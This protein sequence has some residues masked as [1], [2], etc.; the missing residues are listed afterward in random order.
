MAQSQHVRQEEPQKRKGIPMH[1]RPSQGYCSS[2]AICW[3]IPPHSFASE[4]GWAT[5]SEHNQHSGILLQTSLWHHR[6]SWPC[7]CRGCSWEEVPLK[8]V[9]A[10]AWGSEVLRVLV[11]ELCVSE[12]NIWGEK[13]RERLYFMLVLSLNVPYWKS[14]RELWYLQ[15]FH[16]Y[17]TVQ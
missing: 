1:M 9:G 17:G 4:S 7:H 13:R 15:K 12:G 8:L 2:P 3:D 5:E 6:H 16:R 14:W 10:A 11:V